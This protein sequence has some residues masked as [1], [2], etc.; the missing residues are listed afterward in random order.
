MREGLK[1]FVNS[2]DHVNG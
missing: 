2:D 1:V